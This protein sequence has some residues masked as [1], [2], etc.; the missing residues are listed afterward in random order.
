MFRSIQAMIGRLLVI[1]ALAIVVTASSVAMSQP[2][3]AAAA[4]KLTCEQALALATSWHVYADLMNAYG[5]YQ[6]WSWAFGKATY[7]YEYC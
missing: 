6:Q 4:P 1:A 2:S 5:Y 7:Y 3:D